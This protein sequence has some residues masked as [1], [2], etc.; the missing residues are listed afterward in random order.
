MNKI[1]NLI[2]NLALE[3]VKIYEDYD[4]SHFTSN[5][6]LVV[7]GK[8]S[9]V[10]N[11]KLSS[12]SS[13]LNKAIATFNDTCINKEEIANF[14]AN[15]NYVNYV[16]SGKIY[17]SNLVL[18]TVIIKPVYL[19]QY[20]SL[21]QQA[22]DK[23]LNDNL[24]DE[25]MNKYL[26][27]D[28]VNTVKKQMVISSKN[29]NNFTTKDIISEEMKPE[30]Q[31]TPAYIKT[32]VIPFVSNYVKTKLAAIDE[33]NSVLS[34]I[35]K[36]ESDFD[37][38]HNALESMKAD[39]SCPAEK[40]ASISQI[41]Y[42]ALRGLIDLVSYVTFVETRK[43]FN[44]S[45]NIVACERL[46]NKIYTLYDNNNDDVKESV[47]DQTLL[48]IDTD[49]LTKELQN[50]R[51]DGYI[52]IANNIYNFH[53]GELGNISTKDVLSPERGQEPYSRDAYEAIGKAF[54]AISAGL[55]IIGTEGDE[56]LLL[57]DDIVKKSGFFVPLDERFQ[58]EVNAIEDVSAQSDISSVTSVNLMDYTKYNRIMAELKNY[59]DNMTTI[60]KI[61]SETRQ[62][63]LLLIDRFT[64]NVNG[65]YKDTV[66]TQQIIELLRNLRD[67]YDELTATIASK[68]MVRLRTLGETLTNMD[69]SAKRIQDK[70]NL[71]IN[72]DDDLLKIDEST[73]TDDSF[74]KKYSELEEHARESML[75][76]QKNYFIEKEKTLKN[77]NVR[78]I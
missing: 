22:I 20:I 49:S 28:Y 30:V 66:S 65:E 38:M 35:S 34:A 24:S 60:A 1:K 3:E 58:N 72:A 32:V 50:G 27:G 54:I 33:A 77:A 15:Y 4:T 46:Y 23:Y 41:E 48:P 5:A 37:I 51:A 57:F 26:Y 31:V 64:N 53:K 78:F 14:L 13:M 76:L 12:Y 21:L 61:I 39:A 74:E 56:F 2:Q 11:V 25:D 16:T 36:A 29:Y 68:F 19:S 71:N 52:D 47:M 17:M 59:P 73:L 43:L 75:I 6:K 8:P 42:N 55:D 63:L 9:V 69:A 7:T 62:K 45:N 44:I 67:Q 40:L 18:D 10:T 70:S